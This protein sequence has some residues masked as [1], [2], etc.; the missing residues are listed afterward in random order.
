MDF[1]KLTLLASLLEGNS[2]AAHGGGV[3]MLGESLLSLRNGMT[4]RG[5]VAS[6]AGGG[7]FVA[8]LGATIGARRTLL[9]VG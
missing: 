3:A 8:G 6:L 9:C 5:N 4:L 7:L 2:A 1:C